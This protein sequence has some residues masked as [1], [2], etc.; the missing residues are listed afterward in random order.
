MAKKESRIKHD[1]NFSMKSFS[2]NKK[3][4]IRWHDA[5]FFASSNQA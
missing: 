4:G 1:F 3:T 2:P 5:G